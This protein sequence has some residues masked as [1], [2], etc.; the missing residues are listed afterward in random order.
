MSLSRTTTLARLNRP[1]VFRYERMEAIEAQKRIVQHLQPMGVTGRV[2]AIRGLTVSVSDFPAPIGAGCRILLGSRSVEARVIG[3]SG[4]QTLVMPLG[5]TQGIARRDR[6]EFTEVEQTVSLGPGVLGRILDG[7]ARPIDAG[8]T[9]DRGLRMPVWPEPM[10][11]MQRRRIGT[12]LSTGVRAIDAMLTIGQGQRMSILSGSGVGKSVLLGMIGRYTAADVTV[13]ALIGERG[14]EARDFIDREL[15]RE[16]LRKSVVIVSTSDEP[17]LVRVQAAAVAA[18]VAEYFRDRGANVL[19]LMDSLTRLA[20]AQR[21]VGLAA[22]EPP[23]T[24]GYTPSVFELLPRL[25]ERCGRTE[26][27]SITGF[28]TVLVE[29][30]DMADPV[31][32]AVRAVTDGHIWLS[33]PLANRGHYPAID[34][35]QSVS[36]VM[37]DIVDPDHKAAARELQRLIAIH[38]DIEELVNVGAYQRGTSAEYDLA[39]HAL[40]LI[41]RFLAQPIA[42][43]GS[44]AETQAELIDLHAQIMD[45]KQA[46]AADGGPTSPPDR[47]G[48]PR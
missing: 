47:G 15:G 14:R 7:F 20:T 44:F 26:D 22:G 16:G 12:P 42:H 38:D 1:A 48:G 30:D 4:D 39:I 41:R 17:P 19:L 46:T 29:G 45:H 28:Y 3:F 13:I 18:T 11:A 21:Q 24:R 27:G 32:D 31:A 23:A 36:R 35:L 6:V 25:L 40:P 43:A 34:V 33:R 8:P 2:S 37:A 5:A 9:A 10:T